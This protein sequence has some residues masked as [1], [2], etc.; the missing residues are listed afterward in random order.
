MADADGNAGVRSTATGRVRDSLPRRQL[1]LAFVAFL[2]L[3]GQPAVI[4]ALAVTSPSV[5]TFAVIVAG[6][7]VLAGPTA[8]A[9]VGQGWSVSRLADYVLAVAL[10]QIGLVVVSRVAL[11]GSGGPAMV[12]PG[13]VL[14]S[15]PIVYVVLTR[16]VWA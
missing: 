13:I 14:V 3:F 6:T 12:Q 9:Y 5:A 10:V 2:L 1:V 11:A 4:F 16:L 8:R 15:Y 7:A